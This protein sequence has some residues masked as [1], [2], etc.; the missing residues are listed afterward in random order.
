MKKIAIVF[1]QFTVMGGAQ[2]YI[3]ALA[4]FFSGRGYSV[5]IYTIYFSPLFSEYVS[6]EIELITLFKNPLGR[7]FKNTL[8]PLYL[9]YMWRLSRKIS[10]YDVLLTSI[11]PSVTIGFLTSKFYFNKVLLNICFEPNYLLHR[12]EPIPST[13]LDF[14]HRSILAKFGFFLMTPVLLLMSAFDKASMGLQTNIL[15][16]SKFVKKQVEDVYGISISKKTLPIL[17][18]YVDFNNFYFKEMNYVHV[19]SKY[20]VNDNKRILFSVSRLEKTKKIDVIIEAINRL[21]DSESNILLLIGGVGSFRKTLERKVNELNLSKNVIF[22]GYLNDEDLLE[23]YNFSDIFIYAGNV[24]T[25]GPLTI[26]EA[27]ACKTPVICAASGGPLE[28]ISGGYNG[29]FFEV[30]NSEDLCLK[31][32]ELLNKNISEVI[33]ANGYGYCLENHGIQK[34]G[35]VMTNLIEAD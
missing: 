31:I 2:R 22:L 27:M 5:K 8:N 20:G 13:T 9:I 35:R 18:D 16:L 3:L 34:L 10:D 24:E 6:K 17:F 33:A 14:S 30:D 12:Y 28:I 21:K 25:S 32:E 23:V 19:R 15:T 11:W 29:L 7:F 1:P 4:D 26:L